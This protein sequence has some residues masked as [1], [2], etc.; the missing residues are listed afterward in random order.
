MTGQ[1]ETSEDIMKNIAIIVTSLNGGGA[2][3][4]AGL[5]SRELAKRYQVYLFL[6]NAENI[7]YEY[8]GTIIDI[9]QSGPFYEYAIKVYKEKYN[10]DVAISF[11][12]IMNFANIRT[13]GKE[14]IIISERCVQSLIEP[15][16][17]SQTDKIKRYYNFADEAV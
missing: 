12:E 4:I 10:I 3:R 16:L 8:G 9:R 5:L 7:V 6:L 14:R 2:E 17:V 1:K 15:P 11:L 13:R